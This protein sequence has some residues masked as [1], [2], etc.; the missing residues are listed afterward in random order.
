MATHH[1]LQVDEL[2]V[3]ASFPGLAPVELDRVKW[4]VRHQG[5]DLFTKRS[6]Q[7]IDQGG[8]RMGAVLARDKAHPVLRLQ[9]Y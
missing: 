7:G 4:R 1:H 5:R 9:F 3:P 6:S 8:A 2:L